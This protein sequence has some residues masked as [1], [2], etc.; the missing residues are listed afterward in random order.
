[1]KCGQTDPSAAKHPSVGYGWS[2]GD[3]PWPVQVSV[4]G[5][6]LVLLSISPKLP[7]YL[8]RTLAQVPAHQQKKIEKD[9][10]I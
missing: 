5:T 7:K 1:M 6:C 10:N 3:Q 2:G 9:R 8:P 4:F